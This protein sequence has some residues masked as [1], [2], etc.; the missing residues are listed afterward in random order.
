[1]EDKPVGKD[2]LISR[3][4]AIEEIARRDTTN[5]TVK[6]YSGREINEMLN[7]LPTIAAIPMWWITEKFLD[8]LNKDR[9]LSA[10]AW[11]VRHAW[12]KEQEAQDG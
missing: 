10:A 9:A 4:A 12:Q 1:M 6:V 11:L 3:A 2:D 8:V 7:G 5:G